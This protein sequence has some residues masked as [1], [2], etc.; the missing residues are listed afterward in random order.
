MLKQEKLAQ[1]RRKIAAKSHSPI[2]VHLS[3]LTSEQASI[4]STLTATRMMAMKMKIALR[5]CLFTFEEY[6][7]RCLYGSSF[8]GCH[9]TYAHD[10][11]DR[12]V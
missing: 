2:Y 6:L 3:V 4:Q 11:I 1:N 10:P 8:A 5:I 7:F 9:D 12:R